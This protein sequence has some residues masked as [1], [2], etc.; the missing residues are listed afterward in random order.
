MPANYVEGDRDQHETIDR[1]MES[2]APPFIRRKYTG[3]EP[4]LPRYTHVDENVLKSFHSS[5]TRWL[6]ML[7]LGRQLT[8]K[9]GPFKYAHPWTD[10]SKTEE[11]FRSFVESDFTKTIGHKIDQ[12]KVF[13]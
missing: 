3:I 13:S 8:A 12:I 2:L 10:S 11:D 1:L 9:K 5:F 6:I 7:S 4:V